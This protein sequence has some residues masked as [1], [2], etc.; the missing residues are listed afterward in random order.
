MLLELYW[1]ELV[2]GCLEVQ[3]VWWRLVVG[4]VRARKARPQQLL[5]LHDGALR[6]YPGPGGAG[7][8]THLCPSHCG[9]ESWTERQSRPPWQGPQ[10]GC[11]VWEGVVS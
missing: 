2:G 7:G 5:L 10:T 4:T 3:L 11:A 8:G 1:S 6:D 9:R